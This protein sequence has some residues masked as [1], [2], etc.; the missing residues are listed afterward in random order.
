MLTVIILVYQKKAITYEQ[1]IAI[2]RY[3]GRKRKR[4]VKAIYTSRDNL[5]IQNKAPEVMGSR[6]SITL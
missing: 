1:S 5:H 6:C 3:R 2:L 4:D